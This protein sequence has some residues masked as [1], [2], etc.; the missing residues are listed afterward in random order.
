MASTGLIG[1]DFIQMP[2]VRGIS[3]PYWFYFYSFDCAEPMHVHV[4]GENNEAKFWVD[5]VALV[6]NR[7]F[8]ARELNEIRRIIIENEARIVGAWHE[9]CDSD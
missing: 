8:A 5:P 1:T 3:G 6:W 9:H 7:G 2:R 4:R